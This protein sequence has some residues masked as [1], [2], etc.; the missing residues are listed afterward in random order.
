VIMCHSKQ[1]ETDSTFQRWNRYSATGF[2]SHLPRGGACACAVK[3]LSWNGTPSTGR[4]RL[5]SVEVRPRTCAKDPETS[6]KSEGRNCAL[7]GL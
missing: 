3:N 5:A 6:T 1:R 4:S 2:L 7:R